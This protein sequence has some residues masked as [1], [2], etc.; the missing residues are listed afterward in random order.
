MRRI[1]WD[2]DPEEAIEEWY[3]ELKSLVKAE[4]LSVH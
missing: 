2:D 1:D 4:R 3:G